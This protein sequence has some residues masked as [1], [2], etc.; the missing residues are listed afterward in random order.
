MQINVRKFITDLESLA[1]EPDDGLSPGSKEESTM[2]N[3][4]A[5]EVQPVGKRSDG[6]T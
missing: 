2:P 4:D 3:S 5:K 1:D 6:R